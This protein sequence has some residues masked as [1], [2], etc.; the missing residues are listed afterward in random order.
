MG[1]VKSYY[2]RTSEKKIKA[3]VKSYVKEQTNFL[4]SILNKQYE[5][6]KDKFDVIIVN[7]NLNTALEKAENVVRNFLKK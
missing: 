2:E 1:I 5:K 3:E 7:D 6:Y 4:F